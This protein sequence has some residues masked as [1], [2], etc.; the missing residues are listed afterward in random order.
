MNEIL[1]LDRSS[2]HSSTQE[3]ASS[4]LEVERAFREVFRWIGEDPDRD[5]LRETPNR[6]ARAFQEY[7]AGYRQDPEEILQKTFEETDGYDEMV[8]LRGIPFESHC[9]HHVA[10]IGSVRVERCIYAP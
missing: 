4:Q 10:P 6:L 9:E 1:R 2:G 3:T 8:V 5:G 7:F